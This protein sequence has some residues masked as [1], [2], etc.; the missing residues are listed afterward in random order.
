[1]CEWI[2]RI[3]RPVVMVYVYLVE[4]GY[5]NMG[6]VDWPEKLQNLGVYAANKT[7]KSHKALN[8]LE[9]FFLYA[10]LHIVFYTQ[11]IYRK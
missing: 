3:E 7:L 10:V 11:H 2:V 4:F 1:M 8:H 5:T 9:M 6:S